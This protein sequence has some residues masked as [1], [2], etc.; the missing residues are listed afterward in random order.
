MIPARLPPHQ[1]RI[2]LDITARDESGR[3]P[4]TTIVYS[5]P[6]KSGKTTLCGLYTQWFAFNEG[7][8]TEIYVLAN[9]QEQAQGRIFSAMWKSL[10]H[11]PATTHLIPQP[12]PGRNHDRILLPNGTFVQTLPNDYAGAAG[13]NH[14]LT[15]WSELWAYVS[16]NAQRLWTEMT[17]VP[18]RLN[19][20]RFV[21]TY[22]G[23]ED[24]SNILKDLYD[25]NV[26]PEYRIYE[27]GF[28]V[29]GI[30]YNWGLPVYV[31]P[32]SRTYVYWD[33]EPR[34]PWQQ[35]PAYY[36]DQRKRLH[37]AEFLRIHKNQW[38]SSRAAFIT[39][40]MWKA[41]EHDPADDIWKL[42]DGLPETWALDASTKKD[43]TAIVSVSYEPT[44]ELFFLRRYWVWVP[45]DDG[46]I[47][48]E[49]KVIDLEETLEK[50]IREQSRLRSVNAYYYDPY[51]LHSIST[52]L[53]KNGFNMREFQQNAP[54][55]KADTSLYDLIVQKRLIVYPDET[56]KSHVLKA[57]V[58]LSSKTEGHYRLTKS[59]GNKIDL[60]VA[61][62]MAC[63]GSEQEWKEQPQWV[64]VPFLALPSPTR[65]NMRQ[66]QTSRWSDRLL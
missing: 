36:E 11:N 43:A 20:I 27:E 10:Y 48:Q 15:V 14:S 28:E 54:R 1:K 7:A 2:L 55:I 16:E 5:A 31:D 60:A 34:M 53:A 64:D 12:I 39:E 65:Q 18:T 41:C 35:N 50:T 58:K 49:R 26:R 29:D 51:Q 33:E 57:K 42:A 45:E 40:E 37:A 46:E 66:V 62:S 17:P 56:I 25:T 44:R 6:K 23:F 63:F 9:D 30:W 3:F 59:G 38:V 32:S 47:V 8:P 19:S 13:S 4:F 24:E 22:A 61:L 52:G 21:E